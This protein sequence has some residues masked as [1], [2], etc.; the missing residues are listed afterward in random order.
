[1]LDR[2][3]SSFDYAAVESASSQHNRMIRASSSASVNSNSSDQQEPNSNTRQLSGLNNERTSIEKKNF[4][5]SKFDSFYRILETYS[6][7]FLFQMLAIKCIVQIELIQT[8][9]NIIFY[10]STSKKEDLQ[11]I[12]IAHVRIYIYI[13]L[14]LPN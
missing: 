14:T 7:Y 4:S 5:K 8:I 1:M 6:D 11:Y 10:P 2:T 3:D 13:S 9:D 12:S